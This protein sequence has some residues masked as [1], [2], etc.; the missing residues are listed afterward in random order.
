[1]KKL[2]LGVL[3]GMGLS[4]AAGTAGAEEQTIKEVIVRGRVDRP[5]VVIEIARPTATRS[6]SAAHEEM[7]ARLVEKSAPKPMSQKP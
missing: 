5:H 4:L 1:M 6:A 3:V 2:A 7:K